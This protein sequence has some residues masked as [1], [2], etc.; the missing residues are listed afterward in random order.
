MSTIAFATYAELPDL[1]PDDRLLLPLLQKQGIDVQPAVWN[2]GGVDWESFD[3]IVLRSCWDYDE[4]P[5]AFRQ[6][7]NALGEGTVP[8]LNSPG[9]ALWNLDKTHLREL[10]EAGVRVIPT[11]W[12]A[13]GAPVDLADAIRELR[14]DEVVVKPTISLSA[15]GTWRSS[16]HTSEGHETQW[17]AQLATCGQMVQ[18]YLREIES[19][20]EWSLVFMNGELSHTCRK[21]P[22]SGDF[23]VQSDWGGTKVAVEPEEHVVESARR[24]LDAA[25]GPHLYARVDGVIVDGEQTA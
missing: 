18:P 22:K 2:D 12:A 13:Q 20:G 7:L 15:H 1:D 16:V 9:I 21:L 4:D 10:A 17:R 19:D 6:W 23:R 25:P 5:E 14:V 8:V 24:V 11:Y 3:L